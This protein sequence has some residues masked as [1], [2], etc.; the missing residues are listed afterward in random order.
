L[1]VLVSCAQRVDG[2]GDGSGNASELESKS[3]PLIDSFAV[4]A[5]RV[6]GQTTGD[7]TWPD[8]QSETAIASTL[9]VPGTQVIAYNDDTQEVESGH[10]V[11]DD[12]ENRTVYAGASLG[13][14]STGSGGTWTHRGKLL[15]P[16]GWPIIWSDPAATWV[17]SPYWRVFLAYV[18]V[19]DSKYTG[20][21][22]NED[23]FNHIGGA[24]IYESTGEGESFGFKQCVYGAA[25]HPYDGGCLA[26]SNATGEVYGAWLD[27]DLS[28][29]VN[30]V[31]VWRAPDPLQ[32][33]AQLPDPFPGI[34]VTGH[35]LLRVS[36][37]SAP[38]LYVAV[39]AT[40]GLNQYGIYMNRYAASSGWHTPVL[41]TNDLIAGLPIDL[42]KNRKYRVARQFSF[43][44]GATSN[45]EAPEIRMLVTRGDD[46]EQY[47]GGVSCTW[48]LVCH[49]VPEWGTAPARWPNDT[50]EYLP[51]VRATTQLSPTQWFASFQATA[52][53][54]FG[55][56]AVETWGVEFRSDGFHN[57]LPGPGNGYSMHRSIVCETT[58]SGYWGDYNDLIVRSEDTRLQTA[59]YFTTFTDSSQWRCDY[60]RKFV[61][62]HQHVWGA[63]MSP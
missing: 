56:D 21:I 12:H 10:I 20:G 4:V 53:P 29:G 51:L 61:A 16:N 55:T 18:A 6:T 3:Q 11:Y 24:C 31:A 59:D 7:I 38:Q 1:P 32:Y 23:L 41:V 35:P 46:S 60:R 37:G 44:V 47:I 27:V 63:W 48:D 43:D 26:S 62:H 39:A 17:T 15:P 49:D 40:I 33:F 28:T 45:P 22:V 54:E 57:I 8:N 36:P 19:P 5:A 13:G 2:E 9:A 52:G 42:I 30:Q 50:S 25:M 58:Y 14:W 34:S